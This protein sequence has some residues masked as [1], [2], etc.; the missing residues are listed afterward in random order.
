MEI[1]CLRLWSISSVSLIAAVSTIRNRC[2]R[3]R[4]SSFAVIRTTTCRSSPRINGPLPLSFLLLPFVHLFLP[5]SPS[6]VFSVFSSLSLFSLFPSPFYFSFFPF[7]D[8]SPPHPFF[9]LIL[10][11]IESFDAYCDTMKSTAAWGGQVE[12]QALSR[13]LKVRIHIY[14]ADSE[15]VIMGD[16]FP[17]DIYLSYHKFE[18]TLGEHYNS[19]NKLGA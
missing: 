1:A 15:T 19:V 13:L 18:Y 17:D 7:S 5:L 11:L 4:A 8:F 6:S 2:D 3:R 9:L 14:H 16:E 12:L 10:L